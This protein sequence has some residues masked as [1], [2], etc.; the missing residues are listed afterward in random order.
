M[1]DMCP[2]PTVLKGEANAV[3][4]SEFRSR[5][6]ERERERERGREG[7]REREREREREGTGDRI[8]KCLL[9]QRARLLRH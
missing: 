5:E 2:P 4:G 6:R 7:E 8:V 9:C 3:I 1:Y